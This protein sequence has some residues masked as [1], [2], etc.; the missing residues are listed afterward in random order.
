MLA[1]NVARGVSPSH[2]VILC[3]ILFMVLLTRFFGKICL[4]QA[5]RAVAVPALPGGD[6]K[7]NWHPACRTR[8]RMVRP[9]SPSAAYSSAT[10]LQDS[11]DLCK[12]KES[13]PLLKHNYCGNSVVCPRWRS[14]SCCY[15][16]T[17]TWNKVCVTHT[18]T[19]SLAHIST[20]CVILVVITWDRWVFQI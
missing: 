6:V 2:N 16:R 11:G 9:V 14:W 3:L 13:L 19:L 12:I 20:H 4:Q 1:H 8:A 10:V 17:Q 18:H 5:S 15:R 7:R